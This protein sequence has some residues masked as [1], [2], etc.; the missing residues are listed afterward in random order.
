MPQWPPE[1]LCFARFTP[2]DDL[3]W[4]VTWHAGGVRS[5]VEHRPH[6]KS[7]KIT[8]NDQ[9]SMKINNIW[10]FFKI[11]LFYEYIHPSSTRPLPC[12]RTALAWHPP[13]QRTFRG[14]PSPS[15]HVRVVCIG[16]LN[17]FVKYVNIKNHQKSWILI[18]FHWYLVI[19]GH[20]WWFPMR[21]MLSLDLPRTP[22]HDTHH[23][24]ARF[25]GPP[26]PS[27][28][29][30]VVCIGELNVFVKYVK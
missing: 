1:S 25:V 9:K 19:F 20:F 18:D 28:H 29:V 11:C 5:S 17:V 12:A 8:K 27:A 21:P 2:G 23:R 14:P 13:P 22:W 16:E 6:G 26:W 15:A 10:W 7:S 3:G 24:N 30:R 4:C